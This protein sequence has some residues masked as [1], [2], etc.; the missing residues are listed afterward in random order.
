MPIL[1]GPIK[2]TGN[3][4]QVMRVVRGLSRRRLEELSGVKSARIFAIEHEITKP[5]ES[6]V[7]RLL[8]ALTTDG[9]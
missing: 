8:G 1:N 3:S 5:H 2:V 7:A 9:R 6:E 4:L